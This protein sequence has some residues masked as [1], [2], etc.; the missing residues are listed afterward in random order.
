MELELELELEL[1]LTLL[2]LRTLSPLSPGLLGKNGWRLLGVS[3][4]NLIRGS[5]VL[6][7]NLE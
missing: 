6:R 2:L 5:E 3:G 1:T 7:L 4:G